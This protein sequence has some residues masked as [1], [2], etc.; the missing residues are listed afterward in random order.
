MFRQQRI[1]RIPDFFKELSAREGKGVYFYRI[2]G[3]NSEIADFIERYYESARGRGVVIE[4][5]IPNPT[6]QNLSYYGEIMGM[7]FQM[8]ESFLDTSLKKWLPRM[9]DY[10]RHSIA[11]SM[12]DFFL[13]MQKGGKTEGMLKNAYI[14]FM[15][16]LY[17]KFERILNLLGEE[18]IP[19]ILYEGEVSHYELMLLEI[20]CHAGCDIVLLQYHG[21]SSY[22]K[23]D[24]Q[25][26]WS[27]PFILSDSQPFPENYSLA[28]LR[29][30]QKKKME[31]ERLYGKK[32]TLRNATNVWLTGN[33]ILTDMCKEPAQRGSDPDFYYNAYC[34]ISGVEDRLTCLN[35][36]YQ[37]YQK[38]QAQ[39]RNVVVVDG[40][41]KPPTPEEI[42]KIPR[43]N[44][45]DTESMLMDLSANLSYPANPE[46]QRLMVKAFL[47]V[48]LKESENPQENKNKL[49]NKAVYLI[50]FMQRYLS[51][52][53]QGWHKTDIGCFIH[54]GAC[55]SSFEI[56]FV[57]MLARLPVD[58][59]ILDPG[60]SNVQQIQDPLLYE[61]H[62]PE[63]LQAGHF[64][65]ENTDVRMGTA[66]YHAER[67]LDTIMYQD[68][69][70][71]R[72]QQYRYADVINLQTMY[73]EIPLLW[74]EEVR[75]R[76]NFSTTEEKVNLPVIFA[77]ISG[78]R[79]GKVS[80]YWASVKE[81]ITEDTVVIR[82]I[83][84]I[85]PL[86]ENPMKPF[87]VEFYK[88]GR[89]QKNRIKNHPSYPY[90]FLRDEV[91]E[92]ILDKL[93]VLIEQKLIKGTFE[94]GTEYTIISTVLNLPKEILRLLQRFDFTKK[95]P[96][97][98]YIHTGEKTIS[99]EDAILIAFLNLAGFDI[100]F[101]IP[102]G[103]QNIET[104]YNR[105][106]M[107]EHQIGEYLYDL[108]IPDF[109]AVPS[110]V[111]PK[112]WRERLFRR[113]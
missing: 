99:L 97:L 3:Y 86:E 106:Q 100:L 8:S 49:M 22:A 63:R 46:L 88:N 38:L 24:P 40:Q 91:Q 89:L 16:W 96:K 72:N 37:F 110:S 58:V 4:G 98:I 1:N 102:T 60:C 112:T 87:A 35:E 44:Y 43:K 36:W 31:R 76:P 55:N 80:E 7:A 15:C 21:D 64:P 90:G 48:M 14:K 105:R 111:R 34:Q 62:Y 10:Q 65:K 17:Y 73:E 82:S 11:A 103:Y 45:P 109:R 9:N 56:L 25:N 41:I 71:Y 94:N 30:E 27:L 74:K 20:L 79:D 47:D 107:E 33:Q 19:K 75:Y 104:F 68:S 92:H 54:M 84:Y 93:Q 13:S 32:P 42:Q 28:Q 52:L 61:V 66:A 39:K 51:G 18:Q 53:F 69:G 70:M 77:K 101:F 2:S 78:V 85:K 67:D 23:L 113:E 95:N 5:R 57:K 12:Y 81:L 50:C 83:P 26:D 29:K 6:E 59:L 108:S